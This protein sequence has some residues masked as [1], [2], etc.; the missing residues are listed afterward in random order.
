MSYLVTDVSTGVESVYFLTKTKSL[1]GGSVKPA[2]S[3]NQPLLK[4]NRLLDY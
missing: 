4:K 3:K 2:R 1:R